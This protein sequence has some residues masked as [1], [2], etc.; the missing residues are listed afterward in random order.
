MAKVRY[1]DTG[2][3]KGNTNIYRLR[4]TEEISASELENITFKSAIADTQ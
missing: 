3:T 1:T 2:I 4:N